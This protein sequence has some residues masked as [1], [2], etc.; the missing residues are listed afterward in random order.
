V[1]AQVRIRLC[2]PIAVERGGRVLAGRELGSRKARTLLGVL[3]VE[4]G[5]LVTTDRIVDLL[6]TG[7]V[8]RDPRPTSP[9]W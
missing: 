4:R 9:R 8:P 7:E 1:D 5:H 6:W 2:G 3:A